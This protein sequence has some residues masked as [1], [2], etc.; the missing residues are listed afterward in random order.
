MLDLVIAVAA[1]GAGVAGYR[2]GLVAR[3]TSWAG[4]VIGLFA[5]TRFAPTVIGAVDEILPAT[6]TALLAVTVLITGT[7]IGHGLGFL[8]GRRVRTVIDVGGGRRPDR[9]GGAAAGLVGLLVVVWLL[10]PALA[11]VTGAPARLVRESAIVRTLDRVLPEPPDVTRQLRRLLG[12]GTP[13]VF[14]GLGRAPALP[15][16]PANTGLDDAT[17]AVVARSIVRVEGEACGRV[18]TGTGFV[19]ADGL[20]ATNA[21]VVAGEPTTRLTR[22]DGSTVEATLVAFDPERDLAILAAPGIDRPPLPRTASSADSTGAV[23]GHPGGGPLT[24]SPFAAA[25]VLRA[26]GSDIYGRSGAMRQVIVMAADL[27]PG[28]SGSPLVDASGTVVGVAFAIA[29]DRDGVAYALTTG[30]LDAV[31]GTV[32]GAT[33]DAGGCTA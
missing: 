25:D 17:V 13:Q 31:L 8:I 29:P 6:T 30:E 22:D 19:V 24:L 20:V 33:V 3:A 14:G 5:A 26:R 11:D 2:M 23:F 12:P 15:P 7:S 16:A 4:A 10:A 28:D 32:T 18:Q 21:H 27:E 1:V 9:I